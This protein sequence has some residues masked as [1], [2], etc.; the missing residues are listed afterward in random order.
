MFIA[1]APPRSVRQFL[2][3]PFLLLPVV[4]CGLGQ[5]DVCVVRVYAAQRSRFN[6]TSIHA[7]LARPNNRPT[8]EAGASTCAYP[9]SDSDCDIC[10]G[11]IEAV[12]R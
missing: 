5:D 10:G 9:I 1:I 3:V 7:G 11:H 6:A 2:C 12:N 8:E 4:G